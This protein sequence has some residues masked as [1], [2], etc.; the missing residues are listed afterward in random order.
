MGR[1]VLEVPDELQSR[2]EQMA[3]ASG[4]SLEEFIVRELSKRCPPTVPPPTETGDLRELVK[5]ILREAGL[6]EEFTDEEKRQYQP[7]SREERKRLAEKAGRGKPASE[8]I[9]EERGER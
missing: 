4:Q 3:K 7:L 2:W 1:I 9:L 5:A 8:I 6:L